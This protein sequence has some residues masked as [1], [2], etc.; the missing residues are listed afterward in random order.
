M[1]IYFLNKIAAHQKGKQ[2]LVF[3]APVNPELLVQ[4]KEPAYQE[5]LHRAAQY[6]SA[7]ELQYVDFHGQIDQRFFTDHVHLTG[8]GYQ[9]LARKLTENFVTGD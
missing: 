4:V 1:Q 2:T 8:E 5:N 3:M 6:F 7:Q 9:L